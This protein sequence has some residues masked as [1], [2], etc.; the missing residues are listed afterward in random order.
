[1]LVRFPSAAGSSRPP[2]W[3]P[4]APAVVCPTNPQPLRFRK[5]VV[6]TEAFGFRLS[7][8]SGSHHVFVHPGV[9]ELVNLQD[10]NGQAKAYQIRPVL[11]IVERYRLVL[12]E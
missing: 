2:S 9:R 5:A 3:A 6:L 11:K 8:V 10:V 4:P 1:M 12:E 7:R